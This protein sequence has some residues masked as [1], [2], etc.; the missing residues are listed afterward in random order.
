VTFLRLLGLVSLT[1]CSFLPLNAGQKFPESEAF[2]RLYSRPTN[3][4]AETALLKPA[5]AEPA[6]P[7]YPFAP[8]LLQEVSTVSDMCG[9][10][11]LNSSNGLLQVDPEH[12]AVYATIDT[13]EVGHGKEY[14]RFTYV[15]CYSSL[16]SGNHTSQTQLQGIRIT[17]D[18]QGRPAIWE[19]LADSSGARLLFVSQ[20]LE[21]A[22]AARH[23][24][25]LPGRRYAVEPS[26]DT[27]PVVVVARVL[28]DGPM[29][30]GPIIYLESESS[31]VSTVIC[32]C[33][34]AQAKTVA[35][36]RTYEF[37]SFQAHEHL[38]LRVRAQMKN[39]P[40]YW[41]GEEQ[42]AHNVASWLRLPETW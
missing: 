17:L 37:L 38:L 11:T 27:R 35:Q 16:E 33:M 36:T 12:L 28:D 41:P 39:K 15:W 24:K 40:M 8:L 34:P 2:S 13:L 42:A 1:G 21:A 31:E 26:I 20:S 9:P 14:P 23:G 30:M 18:S 5:D 32:R 10:G 22:A 29:P 4:F 6:S 25:V 3:F 19:V 7:F